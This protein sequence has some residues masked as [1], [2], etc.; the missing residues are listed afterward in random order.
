M[1]KKTALVPALFA[2]AAA[3][4][5]LLALN[6]KEH[7]LTGQ[8][9]TAKVLV[10]RA[11]IPERTLV[12][13]GL[14]EV[15]ELPRRYV[16]QDAIEVRVPTDV[17]MISNTVSRVR[18]PKGN[19][20]SQSALMP[21]SPGA[22]LA[23]RVPPGYRA[24][25]LA[26][27]GE[28]RALVKPGDRVDVLVTFDAVLNDGRR[29]KATATL[30]QNILVIAVGRNLGQGLTS[31]RLRLDAAAD[32]KSA[33]F[34]EK[35]AISLAVNPRELQFLALATQQGA[36]SIGIRAPGDTEM[37]PIPVSMLRQLVGG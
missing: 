8:Y 14:V 23:L 7:A 2:V 27:D 17:R 12:Q 34:S 22:G 18:I 24:A 6:S 10:A 19:Q 36:T 3:A 15:A 9:E 13:E 35:S 37:H 29:E 26:I 1:D 20:I 11:D 4:F 21:L 28:M 31:D 5:Y 33:A 25:T 32:E 16:A 30:L